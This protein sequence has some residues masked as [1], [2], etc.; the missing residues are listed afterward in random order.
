[1]ETIPQE[2]QSQGTNDDYILE[3]LRAA[4]MLEIENPLWIVVFGVYSRQLVAFPRFDVPIGTMATAYYPVALVKRMRRI[5]RQAN[6]TT[7]SHEG[8]TIEEKDR[9][10]GRD[11]RER[12]GVPGMGTARAKRAR[13]RIPR[14]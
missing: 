1:M 6:A 8:F 3:M 9:L 5:E 12:S 14:T 10:N 4:E 11:L 7:R 13:V 2:A